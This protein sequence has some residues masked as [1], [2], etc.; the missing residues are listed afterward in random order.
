MTDT[1]K[2]SG[3]QMNVTK[4]VAQ[5]TVTIKKAIT[6]AAEAGADILLTPEGSLSGYHSGFNRQTVKAALAEVT[7]FAK[8]KKLG[9]ALGTCFTAGLPEAVLVWVPVGPSQ[10]AAWQSAFSASISKAIRG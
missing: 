5:N 1:L 2:V 10:L 6:N 7:A 8:D 3:L 4:D 9:L